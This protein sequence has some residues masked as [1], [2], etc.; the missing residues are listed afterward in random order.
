[1]KKLLFCPI[2]IL[3]LVACSPGASP[4]TD[5]QTVVS[6][7]RAADSVPEPDNSISVDK[8]VKVILNV[9]PEAGKDVA[10]TYATVNGSATAGVDYL[11]A[12]GQ[13][14]FP[15]GSSQSQS[16]DMTILGNNLNEP[17]REFIVFLT[18]PENATVGIPGAITIT[19]LD[20]GTAPATNTPM[21]S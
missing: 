6:F 3:L 4:E 12:S 11:P 8:R 18:N 13:L 1:M 9:A 15:A 5:I 7:D 17:D 16:F 20:N 14:I 21:P 10:V 2:L 19:I